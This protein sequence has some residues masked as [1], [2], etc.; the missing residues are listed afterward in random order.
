MIRDCV[1]DFDGTLIDSYPAMASAMRAALASFDIALSDAEILGLLKQSLSFCETVMHARYGV[2]TDQLNRIF[3]REE[4]KRLSDFTPMPGVREVLHAMA[5]QQ[6]RHFL[7]T[8]RDHMAWDILEREGLR[9][10]FAGGVTAEMG[11][12]RKPDPEALLHLMRTYKMRPEATVMIG[13]RPLDVQCGRNAGCHS[14]LLD[15][16]K[17]FEGE[18]CTYRLREVREIMTLFKQ[19]PDL[20]Q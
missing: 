3:R 20:L 1:W 16:E 19:R 9:E 8:H 10:M 12:A 18:M 17:R 6:V 15:P 11:F 14:A 2:D 5:G 4:Q 13:D 7:L